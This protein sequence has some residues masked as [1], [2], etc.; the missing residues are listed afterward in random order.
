MATT[1]VE[2]VEQTPNKL[3]F[4]NQ[5]PASLRIAFTIFGM[6]FVGTLLITIP[7]IINSGD[8]QAILFLSFI[9][10]FSVVFGCVAI[11]VG[12]DVG[13]YTIDKTL[14]KL[15]I[16]RLNLFENKSI[17]YQRHEIA[18]VLFE[19]NTDSDGDK[20]YKIFFVL[21]SGKRIHR[22]VSDDQV[23]QRKM[24]DLIRSYLNLPPKE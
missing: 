11:S 1:I 7:T 3:I 20:Y 24:V 22:I 9:C 5:L 2:I 10:L 15:T 16:K 23:K 13:T 6:G 19:E 21:A 8:N 14:N 18:D 17:E 12:I 4:R